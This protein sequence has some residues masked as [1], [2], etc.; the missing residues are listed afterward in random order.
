MSQLQEKIF[1]LAEKNMFIFTVSPSRC[2]TMRLMFPVEV[3]SSHPVDHEEQGPVVGHCPYSNIKSGNYSKFASSL[4][5]VDECVARPIKQV[6]GDA[7][8]GK[9]QLVPVGRRKK[10][11]HHCTS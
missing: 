4:H 6:A 3:F 9:C 5:V 11:W 7:A 2:L 1:I 10:K 8:L